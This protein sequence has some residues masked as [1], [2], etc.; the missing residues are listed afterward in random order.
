MKNKREYGK[1]KKSRGK[2]KK[3]KRVK[4]EKKEEPKEEIGDVDIGNLFFNFDPLTK[5]KVNKIKDFNF[6]LEGGLAAEDIT[7]KKV[8]YGFYYS[9]IQKK[10]YFN[11]INEM[12]IYNSEAPFNKIGI[13]QIQMPECQT[14]CENSNGLWTGNEKGE[15]L[16]YNLANFE[17]LR[18]VVLEDEADE[19]DTPILK[20]ENLGSNIIVQKSHSLR[21]INSEFKE[22]QRI[23]DSGKRINDFIIL[24]DN[25]LGI[26]SGEKTIKLK[27]Y[28]VKERKFEAEVTA[29]DS[30]I[31]PGK[32]TLVKLNED[33]FYW[34]Y[35]P[36]DFKGAMIRMIEIADFNASDMIIGSNAPM[37]TNLFP[38]EFHGHVLTCEGKTL[39]TYSNLLSKNMD[40]SDEPISEIFALY[41]NLVIVNDYKENYRILSL[42]ED[43]NLSAQDIHEFEH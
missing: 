21:I 42:E 3:Q 23:K 10:I 26:V 1:K 31:T 2:A 24:S 29:E 17:L 22:V 32:K 40:L 13:K 30:F 4:K 43:G 36:S 39:R 6:A 12:W 35:H 14:Y 41:D 38:F 16:I 5:F 15:I 19:K 9:K 34:L 28:L 11:F 8:P 27:K 33:T 18:K 20:I 7:H 37:I 25:I